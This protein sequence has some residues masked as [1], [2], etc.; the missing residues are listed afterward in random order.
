MLICD[1][2]NL[3][4]VNF[5]SII[6]YANIFSINISFSKLT[7]DKIQCFNYLVIKFYLILPYKLSL[8]QL[9]AGLGIL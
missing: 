7:S 2:I 5:Q 3:N 6:A 4:V 1:T 9:E 8:M